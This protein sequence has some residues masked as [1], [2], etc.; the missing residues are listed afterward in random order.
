MASFT[1]YRLFRFISA[2]SANITA[3]LGITAMLTFVWVLYQPNLGP[4]LSQKMG[5]QAWDTVVTG[6]AA[7]PVNAVNEAPPVH[8][9]GAW[10]NISE[11]EKWQD[12]ASLP[13]DV[14]SPILPHANGCT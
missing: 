13:L 1:L 5:W 10:W 9:G 11:I 14:W 6:D 4:G 3:T 2:S 8:L 12:E 7:G